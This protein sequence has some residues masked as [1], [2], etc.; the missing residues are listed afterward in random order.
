MHMMRNFHKLYQGLKRSTKLAYAVVVGIAAHSTYVECDKF[1]QKL[2]PAFAVGT[3][4]D[5]LANQLE[6]G[7][8][9]L[10]SRRS[11]QYHL[12]VA[13]LIKLRQLLYDSPIDHGGVIVVK[14]GIPYVM[15]R[16]PF[17]GVQARPFE[18]RIRRSRSADIMVIA[19][20][21][22]GPWNAAQKQ[23]VATEVERQVTEHGGILDGEW[24]QFL[25]C[26]CALLMDKARNKSKAT[27]YHC[28]DSELI[29]GLWA[30]LG[31]RMIPKDGS[32]THSTTLK[33]I[34]D[35]GVR[36]TDMSPCVGFPQVSL[37]RRDIMIRTS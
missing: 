27:K 4:D 1:Y 21:K 10:F 22:S 17:K 9:I 6:T 11:Y 23:S 13:V 30:A 8:I 5:I 28:A 2:D 7:D 24:M 20:E 31:Y 14:E 12:P 19:A 32:S 16:C 35:R 29:T 26:A 25:P 3:A 34:H 15:E 37:S 36:F 18:E 33:T